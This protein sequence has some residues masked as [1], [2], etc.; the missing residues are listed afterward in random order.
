M[1]FCCSEIVRWCDKVAIVLNAPPPD[2]PPESLSFLL[3]WSFRG[4]NVDIGCLLMRGFELVLYDEDRICTGWYVGSTPL[5]QSIDFPNIYLV[6]LLSF[7][8]LE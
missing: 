2:R 7:A 1:A 8:A 3:V 6:P 4:D 5:C